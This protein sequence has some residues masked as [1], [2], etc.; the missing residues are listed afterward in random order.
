[1]PVVKAPARV[2]STLFF[3]GDLKGEEDLVIDGRVE[4]SIS[5]KQGNITIGE[6]GRV[7]A[8]IEALTILVSGVVKGNLSA[9]DR[10]VLLETGR[11]E[12]N[13]AAK[14]VSLENG[15]HFRGSIDMQ[16]DPAV[17]TSSKPASAKGANGTEQQPTTTAAATVPPRVGV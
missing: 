2:G 6:R 15:C 17:R 7:E 8:D 14:S 16:S 5:L 10:V 11:V 13:I 1:M 9:A 4:G 3:K 12:G